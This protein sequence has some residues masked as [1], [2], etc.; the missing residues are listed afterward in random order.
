MKIQIYKTNHKPMQLEQ[1][2]YYEQPSADQ[3]QAP[4]E[5]LTP[6]PEY[7]PPQMQTYEMPPST[8]DDQGIYGQI[9]ESVA[10]DE[11]N[12]LPRDKEALDL[13][14]EGHSIEQI[15]ERRGISIKSAR[16]YLTRAASQLNIQLDDLVVPKAPPYEFHVEA[17]SPSDSHQDREAAPSEPI[18]VSF[19]SDNQTIEIAGERIKLPK[20]NF[21]LLEALFKDPQ[22][23]SKEKLRDALGVSRI[24]L[25]MIK[26]KLIQ[27]LQAYPSLVEFIHDDGYKSE[28]TNPLQIVPNNGESDTSPTPFSVKLLSDARTVEIDGKRIKLSRGYYSLLEALVNSPQ[29]VSKEDLC[30][31]LGVSLN[32]LDVRKSRLVKQLADYPD[33][34][35]AIQTVGRN[36]H[37]QLA[38]VVNPDRQGTDDFIVD[39]GDFQI[40]TQ[41][42]AIQNQDIHLTST[43]LAVFNLFNS[44]RGVLITHDDLMSAVR[45]DDYD[46]WDPY[47][48][49][50]RL[51][52]KLKK[53]GTALD[54]QT[55]Q[56]EGYKLEI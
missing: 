34:V 17:T 4:E 12:L 52:N 14:R 49:V 8:N 13:Y 23:K 24:H 28:Q 36:K 27:K 16:T 39:M 9:S 11:E 53:V 2:S 5:H 42:G 46:S 18:S 55:I 47:T 44:N 37:L 43:E 56:G 54:I 22:G 51:R 20:S 1:K 3:S 40:N 26:G 19:F 33:L 6:L 21:A 7:E 32:T 45:E 10:L 29:G 50:S 35:A 30:E 25:N 48:L 31:K 15:A 41:T 38:N